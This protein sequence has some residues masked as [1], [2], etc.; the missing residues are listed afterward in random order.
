MEWCL[1]K[2]RENFTL[3]LQYNWQN[4]SFV[5]FNLKFLIWDGKTKGF[6]LNDSNYSQKA[7]ADEFLSIQWLTENFSGALSCQSVK[8]VSNY[9]LVLTLRTLSSFY[10]HVSLSSNLALPVG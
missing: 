2:H 3:P 4:Y 7:T 5:Y 1:V 9:H 10:F 6:V 8:L